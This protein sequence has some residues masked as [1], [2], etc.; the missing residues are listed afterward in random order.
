MS[1]EAKCRPLVSCYV[2]DVVL[3]QSESRVGVAQ[4]EFHAM[5]DEICVSCVSPWRSLG[6]NTFDVSVG[7]VV[8]VKSADILDVCAYR[9]SGRVAYVVPPRSRG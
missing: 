4:V 6:K 8:L 5:V 2:G 1:K 3:V 9:K 7:S